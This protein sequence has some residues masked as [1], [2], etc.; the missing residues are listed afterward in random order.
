MRL[1]A[2]SRSWPASTSGCPSTGVSFLFEL[3]RPVGPLVELE[4]PSRAAPRFTGGESAQRL[5]SVDGLARRAAKLL[6][7][8]VSFGTILLHARPCLVLADEEG[9]SRLLLATLPRPTGLLG[10]SATTDA[11]EVIGLVRDIEG[12]LRP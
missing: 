5:N 9:V 2:A 3:A 4:Q 12:A 8:D 1:A 10:Q 6:R 7:K 11:G